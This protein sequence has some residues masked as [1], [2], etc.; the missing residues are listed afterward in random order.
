MKHQLHYMLTATT[1][2]SRLMIKLNLKRTPRVL[3]P[4]KTWDNSVN[5]ERKKTGGRGVEQESQSKKQTEE[6]NY[7]DD[8]Q[9]TKEPRTTSWLQEMVE[10]SHLCPQGCLAPQLWT[11]SHYTLYIWI[12]RRLV[13]CLWLIVFSLLLL[14]ISYF[15]VS[16][17]CPLG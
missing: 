7:D 8:T 9:Q 15:Y 4:W 16:L 12:L 10:D 13:F 5:R 1:A 14:L 17:N 11:R 2:V 3:I 6:Y